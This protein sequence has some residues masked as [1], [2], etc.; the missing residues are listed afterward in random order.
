MLSYYH[1]PR[2]HRSGKRNSLFIQRSQNTNT[3]QPPS[4]RLSQLGRSP[5]RSG[6][7]SGLS[8]LSVPPVPGRKHQ[9]LQTELWL[10]EI[11]D[12]REEK[13]MATQVNLTD[14]WEQGGTRLGGKRRIELD[15]KINM[16]DK[17]NNSQVPVKS[18][19]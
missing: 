2:S 16:E 9:E 17:V 6:P 10:E 4:A 11:S 12:K 3:N 19:R 5:L 7:R 14:D 18:Q 15:N 13:E 1:T 8:R